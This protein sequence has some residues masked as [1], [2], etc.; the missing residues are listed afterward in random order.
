MS[1][2]PNVG[3]D[4]NTW[5]NVLNDFLRVEHNPDGSLKSV[6]RPSDVAAKYTKPS[7]GIPL[8]DLDS[9]T[10]GKVTNP[11]DQN[12]VHKGDLVINVKDYGAKGD[13]VTDDTAAIQAT[14]NAANTSAGGIVYLP[15]GTYLIGA[16]LDL[17]GKPKVTLAGADGLNVSYPAATTIKAAAGFPAA[18]PMV[19]NAPVA[20][21]DG[22]NVI[23]DLTLDGTS[24]AQDGV[25]ANLASGIYCRRVSVLNVTRDG[26]H[27][28]G[29]NQISNCECIDTYVNHAGNAAYYHEGLYDRFVRAISDG[30]QYGLYGAVI[31]SNALITGC[32]FEGATVAGIYLTDYA[33]GSTRI[34]GN[35]IALG[36]VAAAVVGINIV[37]ANSQGTIVIGNAIN[38]P[39]LKAGSIGIQLVPLGVKVIGNEIGGFEIGA[40]FGNGGVAIGNH[41]ALS[42]LAG[43]KIDSGAATMPVYVD[44]NIVTDAATSVWHA[45]G[46]LI[47]GVNYCTGTEPKTGSWGLYGTRAAQQILAT[48]AGHTVDNVIA[49]LQAIGI[50]R[51]A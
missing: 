12:A 41:S 35:T 8:S 39:T 10:Q 44:G 38:G 24:R 13:G 1:R 14:I 18:T 51:Q 30:G 25:Y 49:A 3:G 4:D 32:H 31:G 42:D 7:S 2:L 46:Q 22:Q 21:A 47:Y 15:P 50:V 17:T 40:V 48:G 11:T 20:A 34:I 28:A 33:G 43:I 16:A 27:F 19:K 45:S 23:R 5:G 37:H 6:A 36:A 9:A 26:F 29:G